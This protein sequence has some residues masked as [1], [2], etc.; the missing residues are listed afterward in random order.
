MNDVISSELKF[1]ASFANAWLNIEELQGDRGEGL[2]GGDIDTS[3]A[4]SPDDLENNSIDNND[5]LKLL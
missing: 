4:F 5:L 1:W 3:P 2:F